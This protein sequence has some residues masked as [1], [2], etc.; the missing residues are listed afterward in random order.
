MIDGPGEEP[1]DCGD[2]LG[3][4]APSAAL[5]ARLW[6]ADLGVT[7]TGRRCSPVVPIYEALGGEVSPGRGG[8]AVREANKVAPRPMGGE[9]TLICGW[10]NLSSS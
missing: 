10:F 4:G 5:G 1:T 7:N 2:P 8:D 6:G 3:I 9:R